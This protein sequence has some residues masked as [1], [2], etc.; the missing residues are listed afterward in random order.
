MTQQP[1]LRRVLAGGVFLAAASVIIC[2]QWALYDATPES[3][4][5]RA[6]ALLAA[7]VLGVAG[8]RLL[9]EPRT[10]HL[11]GVRASMFAAVALM[12]FAV[13]APHDR[14]AALVAESLCGLGAL[15]ASMAVLPSVD[16]P[17]R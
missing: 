3:Q 2:G 7:T 16:P 8:V 14:T 6:R 12:F 4:Q 15:L 1:P 5:N 10:D 9:L 13:F 17:R 11:I